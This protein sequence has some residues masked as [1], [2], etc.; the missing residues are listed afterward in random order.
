MKNLL[1]NKVQL[2]LE[3]L[4]SSGA[5][6]INELAEKFDI[7]LSTVSRIISDMT[8]MKLVEKIDF[9]RVAPAAGLIRL[10]ESARKHSN[11]V[12]RTVPLLDRFAEQMQM[13]V[14]LAGFEENT[15][16]PLYR[17]G[18][19]EN[20]SNIIWESG[21][22]LVLM[23]QA[24]LPFDQ[25][26]ELFLQNSPGAAETELLIFSRELE[27]IKNEQ[28]LFRSNTMRQWSC[29]CGFHYRGLACGFC[30]YGTAAPE[31]SREH[32]IMECARLQSRITAIFSEE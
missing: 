10:G 24:A 20:S 23:D 5:L 31:H 22:A 27:N 17:R 11:L 6:S 30:V 4:A 19:T 1:L 21:L 18:K 12:Q 2:I 8:E 25:C 15:C 16:F 3:A 32:F 7:P 9:Y 28:R 14:I 29:C 13:N 26:R